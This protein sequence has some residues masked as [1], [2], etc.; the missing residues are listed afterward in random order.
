MQTLLQ[1]FGGALNGTMFL[2]ST[3][4]EPLPEGIDSND[5]VVERSVPIDKAF[6]DALLA[7]EM[8]G[9]PIPLIHG[10]PLRLIVPGYYGVNSVKYLKKISCTRRGVARRN[11]PVRIASAADR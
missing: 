3:G 11:P 2:T 6:G 10:G 4:G 7:W 8:N 9:A 1:H 5:L